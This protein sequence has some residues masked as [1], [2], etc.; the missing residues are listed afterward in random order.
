M[1][2]FNKILSFFRGSFVCEKC[3]RQFYAMCFGYGE[4]VCP[5]CYHGERHF[6]SFDDDFILNRMMAKVMDQREV[7][8]KKVKRVKIPVDEFETASEVEVKQ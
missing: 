1:S 4:T 5:D 6:I 2:L 8:F 3:G 7:Q